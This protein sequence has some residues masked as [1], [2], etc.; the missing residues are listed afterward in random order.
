MPRIASE[1]AELFRRDLARLLQELKAFSNEEDLWRSPPG[2]SNSAGNL[3][4]HL[5]GNL[6]EYI[7]RQLGHVP[8]DRH[9]SLEFSVREIAAVELIQRIGAVQELIPGIVA[10]LSIGE[11]EATYPEEVFG[12]P[13]STQ[14][15]LIS[16]HGHLNYHL[17]QVD[18]LRRILTQGAA[19][20][21]DYNGTS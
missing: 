1:I 13:I 12:A 21:F 18:Y 8:Y 19:I 5:E 4:L 17:G 11:L 16:L 6:R 9:R 15:F 20:E 10:G 2:I 7:G 3:A 14:Q